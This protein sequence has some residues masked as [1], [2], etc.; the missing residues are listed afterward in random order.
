MT[1]SP[2]LGAAAV[3]LA[4]ATGDDRVRLRG[5]ELPPGR[6]G[7]PQCR[8][9]AGGVED[10][11][12]RGRGDRVPEPGQLALDPPMAPGWVRRIVAG[13]TGKISTHRRR[14]TSRDNA[15]SHSR[16]A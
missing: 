1:M 15:V 6:P 5:E 2:A 3:C 7:P 13:V 16:S 14:F 10:L 12:H 9:D 8:V 4:L 11:P